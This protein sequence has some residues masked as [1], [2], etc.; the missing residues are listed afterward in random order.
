[1]ALFDRSHTSAYR[2]SII[3]KLI[4]CIFS[5]INRDIVES[6]DF[7]I[8]H[9]FDAN[10]RGIP[11]KY[12]HC[13]KVWHEKKLKWCGT[14]RWKKF[15]DM[16]AVSTQYRRVTDRQTDVLRQHSPRYAYASCGKNRSNL[17][18]SEFNWGT[19]VDGIPS[20]TLS[21][22]NVII[23]YSFINCPQH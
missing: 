21:R 13:R 12:C 18:K 3:T 9:A 4:Y 6:R 2:P 14:R 22:C 19:E 8:P 7:F 15:D 11:S 16:L 23:V 20:C 10:D 5:E 1:M 17:P